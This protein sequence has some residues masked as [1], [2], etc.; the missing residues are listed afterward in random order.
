M[1]N[2][3]SGEQRA[4]KRRGRIVAIAAAVITTATPGVYGAWQAAK[5]AWQQRTER[6]VNDK[7]ADNLQAWATSAKL[8]LDALEKTCVTHRELIDLVGKLAPQHEHDCRPG[9]EWRSGRCRPVRAV[10]SS[11]PTRRPPPAPA[12][13]GDALAA[14]KAKVK[15]TSKVR[16]QADAA[17]LP[18]L[19]KPAAIRAQ[20]EQK[21]AK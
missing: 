1:T 5:T 7:T 21:A 18:K 20:I 4:L 10:A 15:A 17:R 2:T 12:P 14:L 9:H 3:P 8:K 19:P 13:P 11:P 6:Q 16:A